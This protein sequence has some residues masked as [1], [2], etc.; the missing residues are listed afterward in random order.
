MAKLL[1]RCMGASKPK[2]WIDV[3]A[4]F[5]ALVNN[6][7]NTPTTYSFNMSGV[8]HVRIKAQYY[9][10]N[11]SDQ[12]VTL[13]YKDTAYTTPRIS[14]AE[15]TF[16]FNDSGLVLQSISDASRCV[17]KGVYITYDEILPPLP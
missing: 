9:L 4:N 12:S 15:K 1:V 3:S 14:T 13:L 8:K 17:V 10:D 11:P 6:F 5:P 16:K 2:G 7:P